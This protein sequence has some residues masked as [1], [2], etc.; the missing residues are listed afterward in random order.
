[1]PPE[2]R[3]EP[4]PARSEPPPAQAGPGDF[5]LDFEEEEEEP[6]ASSRRPIAASMDQALAD[7]AERDV[8]IKTPPPESGPQEASLPPSPELDDLL[9]PGAAEQGAVET[10]IPTSAQL[11]NTVSLEEGEPAQLEVAHLPS[12][13]PDAGEFVLHEDEAD[14][15][16]RNAVGTY[17]LSL[18]PPPEAAGDLQR[19]NEAEARRAISEELADVPEMPR[20]SHP[21]AFS[22]EG[23]PE[24]IE[25]PRVHVRGVTSIVGAAQRFQPQTFLELLDASLKL[26]S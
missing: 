4:P 20:S 17:D 15:P 5:G 13:Q 1:M 18:T 21:E 24:L 9:N 12:D 19:H 6:P 26:G 10:G 8:P 2:A 25:R 7:A 23:V 16:L 3:S 14:I 11:G 22:D